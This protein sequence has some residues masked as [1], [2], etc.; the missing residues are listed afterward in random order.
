VTQYVKTLA[1][2]KMAAGVINGRIGASFDAANTS[3]VMASPTSAGIYNGTAEPLATIGN[4]GNFSTGPVAVVSSYGSG[5]MSV[6]A[7]FGTEATDPGVM[8]AITNAYLARNN[9]SFYP[10]GY[11][12]RL[13]F[14]NKVLPP[15][16]RQAYSGFGII[17]QD[18]QSWGDSL[19]AGNQDG[20]GISYPALLGALFTPA[21]TTNNEGFSGHTSTQ[22]AASFFADSFVWG[23]PT[24]I[25]SGRNDWNLSSTVQSNIAQMVANLTTPD[26]LVL[27]I[28]NTENEPSG[29]ST[30]ISI[31]ALNSALASTYGTNFL[32]IRASLVAAYNP[33]N[34]V[35]VIDHANG[36]PPFTLRANIANGTIVGAI[37][38][39]DTSFTTSVA[40]LS[41]DIL[42]VGT[43]Y[44]KITAATGTS[45][46]GCIRG[47]AGTT[48]ASY[49]AGQAFAATDLEHFGAAGYAVVAQAVHDKIMA[50]GW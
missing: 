8:P 38:P 26:Y 5:G 16:T 1:N 25:W 37:A 12:S 24:V 49:G 4:N 9:V 23:K 50:M 35:D 15:S 32:D 7:N 28:T 27:S 34:P 42:T 33:A 18:I 19:T 30:Y 48:A 41:G 2:P 20:T 40:V 36:I 3:A 17:P 45:V 22:I 14:W 11:V 44:I 31:A 13:S 10:D 21:R 39:T 6:V 43:E 47:Y 29:G 46:T